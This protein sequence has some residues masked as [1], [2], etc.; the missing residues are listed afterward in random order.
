MEKKSM[1]F[2]FIVILNMLLK[3][4]ALSCVSVGIHTSARS[5]GT[6]SKLEP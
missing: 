5:S 3:L 6:K 2:F 1:C 4:K